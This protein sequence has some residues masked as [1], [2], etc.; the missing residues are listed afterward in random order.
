M[1]QLLQG[2]SGYHAKFEMLAVGAAQA[3]ELETDLFG[4]RANV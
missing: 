4:M 2:T 3:W 1:A